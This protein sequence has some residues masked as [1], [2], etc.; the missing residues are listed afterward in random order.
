[1]RVER[2]RGRRR[3]RAGAIVG[4]ATRHPL[5]RAPA[6][7]RLVAR[8]GEL[9]FGGWMSGD[10]GTAA[11][12]IGARAPRPSR[13]SRTV[14]DRVR[15][16]R[17]SRRAP[18]RV[19]CARAPAQRWAS[20]RH[21]GAT[22]SA[23]VFRRAPASRGGAGSM[24]IERGPNRGVKLYATVRVISRSYG[25]PMFC[26]RTLPRILGEFGVARRR[27]WCRVARDDSGATPRHFCDFRE[28]KLK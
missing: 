18:P 5:A 11:R 17:E 15:R 16:Q 6:R 23:S 9:C 4:C 3:G 27:A 1:M 2:R 7:E 12:G 24:G 19:G 25:T 28:K 22:A 26:E 10:L 8:C 13:A 20:V 14:A 21:G